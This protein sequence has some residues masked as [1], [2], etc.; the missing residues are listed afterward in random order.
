MHDEWSRNIRKEFET[1]DDKAQIFSAPTTVTAA[2]KDFFQTLQ[3]T[4]GVIIFLST[5]ASFADNAALVAK[6]I[7][8]G[9]S[10]LPKDYD[11]RVPLDSAPGP[12][13]HN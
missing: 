11:P 9:D 5:T 7:T 6:K 1:A 8:S 3:R 10:D 4:L 12:F 2:G 13:D